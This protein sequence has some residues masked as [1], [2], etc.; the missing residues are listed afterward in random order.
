MRCDEPPS[1]RGGG[2]RAGFVVFLI[3]FFICF[4]IKSPLGA[5]RQAFSAGAT[6]LPADL[7]GDGARRAR[8]AFGALPSAPSGCVPAW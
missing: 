3:I 4:L 8:V 7:G 2:G 6:A 1:P 5:E